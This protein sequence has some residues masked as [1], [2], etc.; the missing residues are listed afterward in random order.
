MDRLEGRL[1]T[2]VRLLAGLLAAAVVALGVT[3]G[4]YLAGEDE[5][6]GDGTS[7]WASRADDPA[8][9]APFWIAAALSV[10]GVALLVAGV[11]TGRL[12]LSLAGTLVAGLAVVAQAYTFVAY[13]SN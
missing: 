9:R 7:R 1:R 3:L 13:T 5:Y 4:V 2:L 10:A 6:L 8:A 12:R 11:R